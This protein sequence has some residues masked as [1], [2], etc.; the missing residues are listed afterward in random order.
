MEKKKVY[1][2][3]IFFFVFFSYFFF[4]LLI[5][6]NL[7]TPLSELLLHT[8]LDTPC[9]SSFLLSPSLAEKDRSLTAKEKR[10][11]HS[12]DTETVAA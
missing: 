3:S 2:T 7:K 6:H 9:L 1:A 8:Q 11:R 5:F 12:K 4:S 10:R